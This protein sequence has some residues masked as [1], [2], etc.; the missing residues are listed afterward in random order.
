M[1]MRARR[2]CMVSGEMREFKLN[3]GRTVIVRKR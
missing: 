2:I 3:D 1:R